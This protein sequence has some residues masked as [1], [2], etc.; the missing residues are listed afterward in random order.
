M[1]KIPELRGQLSKDLK[2]TFMHLMAEAE[3]YADD[4]GGDADHGMANTYVALAY[5]VEMELRFRNPRRKPVLK[6]APTKGPV[7]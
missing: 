3:G 6:T 2:L 5:L 7:R 4:Y 1:K